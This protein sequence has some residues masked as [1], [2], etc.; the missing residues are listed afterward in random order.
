M[1]RSMK[2]T[3]GG[4][5]RGG[6]RGGGWG[7]RGGRSPMRGGG[8]GGGGRGRGGGRGGMRGGSKVCACTR[9]I[10]QWSKCCNLQACFDI[11][12]RR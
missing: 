7:D 3:A 8:R 6:G 2:F 1:V 9:L 12:F 11:I 4:F 5:G 10:S